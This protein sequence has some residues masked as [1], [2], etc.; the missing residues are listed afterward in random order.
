MRN[1]LPQAKSHKNSFPSLLFFLGMFL[2]TKTDKESKWGVFL[3]NIAKFGVYL[4]YRN[5][6]KLFRE[7]R[8]ESKFRQRC[9]R[10][11]TKVWERK[12]KSGR[13]KILNFGNHITEIPVAQTCWLKTNCGNTIAE[14]RKKK[15]CGNAIAENGKKKKKISSPISV[16]PLPYST[17]FFFYRKDMCT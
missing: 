13:E 15:F 9:C 6:S 12:R 10:N 16:M 5:C 3:I 11:S 4:H 14:I 2:K 8:K 17:F 7:L 1:P